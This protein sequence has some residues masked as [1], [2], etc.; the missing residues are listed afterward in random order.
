[1]RT[2]PIGEEL[3]E[4]DAA[5]RE[6]AERLEHLRGAV[7]QIV[8]ARAEGLPVSEIVSSGPGVPARREVRSSWSRLNRAL[9]AYRVEVVRALVD[10]EDMSISDVARLTGNARQVASR[11]YHAS[12]ATRL[13]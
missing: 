11:L 1:M 13:G 6:L 5:A 9:H 8:R 7:E 4:L 3:A 2:D 10:D 12:S